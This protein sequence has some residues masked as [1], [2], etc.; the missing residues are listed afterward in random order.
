M[1]LLDDLREHRLLGIIRGTDAAASIDT[2]LAL[3]D[4][5]VR[6]FEV[7]LTS[8]DA[9]RVIEEIATRLDGRIQLG[10][11]TVLTPDQVLRVREAGATY[12]VTP[13]VAPSVPAAIERGIP[14]LCGAL[15]PTEIV[16]AVGLGVDAVK[17]FPASAMG[18]GYFKDLRAPFP[19]VPLVP[20]GGVGADT[21]PAYLAN[22]AIA[23]G[24][25]SPLCGDA[26]DGGDLNALRVRARSFH[27]AVR[28]QA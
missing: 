5:G 3:A 9:L 27:A 1:T 28:E 15:T 13:A 25:A 6:L 18:P 24:V 17:I 19:E 12:V 8:A 11:G 22:G 14:V 2:A 7:S 21:V 4:E 10:A 23:V 20:V 16:T 26:P